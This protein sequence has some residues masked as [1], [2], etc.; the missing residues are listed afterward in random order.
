[1]VTGSAER[2]ISEYE[3]DEWGSGL[4][5]LPSHFTQSLETIQSWLR[6][7]QLWTPEDRF[8][9]DEIE[10]D[11][12]G[13]VFSFA[14]KS[15]LPPKFEYGPRENRTQ[16]LDLLKILNSSL[17]AETR[18]SRAG[19]FKRPLNRFLEI[20]TRQVGPYHPYGD[21]DRSS[22]RVC[23]SDIFINPFLYYEGDIPVQEDPNRMVVQIFLDNPLQ[24][25]DV[26]REE[27]QPMITKLRTLPILY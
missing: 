12:S 26:D 10:E 6:P 19:W 4:T 11:Y 9:R 13:W 1:M 24:S 27:D 15:E 18:H 2:P 3:K 23:I 14:F 5:S 8:Y 16:H 22:T 17:K 7:E 25:L 20:P 21:M